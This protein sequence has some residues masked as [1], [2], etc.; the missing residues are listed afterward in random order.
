MPD[1]LEPKPEA[2]LGSF[3]VG[4]AVGVVVGLLFAPEPGERF[5]GK[6][7]HRLHRLRDLARE[8]MAG[9]DEPAG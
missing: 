9:E 6:L 4:V 5:R 2:G 8:Q 7:G 3:V 1:A